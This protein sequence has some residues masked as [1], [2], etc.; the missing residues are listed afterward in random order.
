M[1][2]VIVLTALSIIG[3]GFAQK[4]PFKKAAAPTNVIVAKADILSAEI[5]KNNFYLFI[6]GKAKKDTM[7]IK[8]VDPKTLPAEG[9]IV[10]FTAKGIPLYALSWTETKVT[11]TKLKKEEAI[12]TNTEIYEVTSKTKVLENAQTT[13]KITEQVF[14]DKN[15]TVSETQQKLRREGFEFSL[16]PTGDVVLKNKTQENKM[17]Y[18]VT[19]KKFV[20]VAGAKKK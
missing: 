18:N 16:T 15:H 3:L 13:T 7:L 2:K 12:T 20:N 14:L 6:N 19:D 17:T 4:K 9:K 11:E 10:P 1:K 5:T 8:A